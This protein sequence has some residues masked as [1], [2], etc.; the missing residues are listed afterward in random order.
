MR[1]LSIDD[2]VQKATPFF[3]T[4]ADIESLAI[5]ETLDLLV[6][7]RNVLDTKNPITRPV[8]AAR[9]F[10]RDRIPFTSLGRLEGVV[11]WPGDHRHHVMELHAELLPGRWYPA[12]A[13]HRD[14][15]F[16]RL[17]GNQKP[18]RI[19]KHTLVGIRGPMMRWTDVKKMDN[20]GYRIIP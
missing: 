5:G 10:A 17:F 18:P 16:Q 9:Y 2:W 19:G 7:H 8:T 15:S 3:L 12:S 13:H 1:T 20:R 14:Q 6:L 11:T 4:K